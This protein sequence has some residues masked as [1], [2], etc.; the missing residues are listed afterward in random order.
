MRR[1]APKRFAPLVV[2]FAV[3]GLICFGA[4]RAGHTTRAGARPGP[5][6]TESL[7]AT[8]A[9]TPDASLIY[10][11]RC[12]T[13]HGKDGRAKTFKG[14]LKGARNLTD[15]QWQ[16]EVTDERI[17]NSIA[18]GRAGD[19]PSFQ[20]KLTEAEIQSLVGYVRSLKK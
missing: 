20:K 3:A 18:R 19:M 10:A 13:C 17:F 7:G 1:V 4:V 8:E 9:A 15:E 12:A 6:E 14:K 11:K 2:T 5:D 16:A